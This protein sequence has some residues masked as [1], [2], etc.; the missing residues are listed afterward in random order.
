MIVYIT[1]FLVM[2][3]AQTFCLTYLL[4]IEKL[5][6]VRVKTVKCATN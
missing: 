4:S 3:M 1:I 5:T 6:K 2:K